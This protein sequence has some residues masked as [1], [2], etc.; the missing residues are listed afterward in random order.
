MK[1]AQG[2]KDSF[3]LTSKTGFLCQVLFDGSKMKLVDVKGDSVLDQKM[4]LT[5]K[6]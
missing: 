1:C 4:V 5:K 2:E 6:N 3:F